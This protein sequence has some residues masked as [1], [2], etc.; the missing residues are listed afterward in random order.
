MIQA[1]GCLD[2]THIPT[3]YPIEYSHDYYYYK[4]FYSPSVQAVCDYKG[5]SMNVECV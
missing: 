3:V 5:T 1:F 2:G 4:Q